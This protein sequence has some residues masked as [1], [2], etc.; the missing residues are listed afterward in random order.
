MAV[1]NIL[2][3]G[4]VVEDMSTIYVPEEVI[5]RLAEIAKSKENKRA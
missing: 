4:T 2:K 5:E 3:N 1:V